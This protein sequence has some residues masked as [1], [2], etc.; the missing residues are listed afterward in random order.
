VT[1][2][3]RSLEQ[4]AAWL[5][6]LIDVEKQPEI[7]YRRLGL[8]A[9]RALLGR[10]GDPQRGLAV[11]HVAGSKGKGSTALLAESI[12]RAAGLRVGTFTSPHLESWTER[13][14]VG[15]REVEG[16][17]LAA[18]VER[19]RPHAEALRAE[20]PAAAPTFFDAA[21]AAA[22]LLFRE[23]GVDLAVVEVGLGGRLDSTNAVEPRVA[24]IAS[25]ELEHTDRLGP[26][27]A[28]IAREKAGILKPGA[29]A[30]AGALP[31]EARA[32]VAERARECGVRVAWL[33][34]DF[35]AELLEAGARGLRVRLRDGPL[36]LEARLPVLG[37]HQA[38][39]AAL[40]LACV[41]RSRAVAEG[42]LARAA[43]AGLAAAR[44]PGRVELLRERPW[45]VVDGA[46]TVA[47]ARALARA[48]ESL[49]RRRT[50]LVLSVS[51][52]K[53]L[54]GVL[55]A[56][57]PAADEVTLTRAEPRRSLAPEAIA[58][59]LRALAPGLPLRVVPDPRLALRSAREALAPGDCL[60]AT[61]SVYLAG[62]ARAVL[63]R[64]KRRRPGRHVARCA[65]GGVAD[66]GATEGG[67]SSG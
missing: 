36:E 7:P 1:Q 19:L 63:A 27:L 47:S 3:I 67:C 18:A 60:C 41:R 65:T 62:I 6:G 61:G 66:P 53:D 49:P 59:S 9:I 54:A 42:E 22:L 32:V 39:N 13:F 25:I 34:E 23:A 33:G 50:H 21:T 44:L 24:C 5:E 14:R 12:L 38:G 35:G 26:T 30:V 64:R 11:I 51:A 46:H 45:I 43:A 28:S 55:A 31:E 56:L 37:A 17:R 2:P 52:D 15:G 10:L 40:A 48:L 8:E 29:E 16:A 58:G 57:A 4:A 20:G